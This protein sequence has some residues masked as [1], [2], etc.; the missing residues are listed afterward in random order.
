MSLKADQSLLLYSLSFLHIHWYC[1]DTKGTFTLV[2]RSISSV[3]PL[4]KKSDRSNHKRSLCY[5]D[6]K[7]LPGILVLWL[8]LQE[9]PTYL[10]SLPWLTIFLILFLIPIFSSRKVPVHSL[11]LRRSRNM[12]KKCFILYYWPWIDSFSLYGP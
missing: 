4:Q 1:V 7:T 5:I 11:Q 3:S 12:Q 8:P 6:Y 9:R 10:A 2:V